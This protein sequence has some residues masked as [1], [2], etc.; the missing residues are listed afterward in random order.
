[1]R[2]SICRPES[3]TGSL[4]EGVKTF[5]NT[6]CTP[7]VLLK[8]T[9]TFIHP[10]QGINEKIKNENSNCHQSENHLLSC[11]SADLS[12]AYISSYKELD[13]TTSAG[14]SFQDNEGSS[15]LN[16]K[17]TSVQDN[18]GLDFQNNGGQGGQNNAGSVIQD[19]RGLNFQENGGFNFHN[20][21]GSDF[22]SKR[23]SDFQ[24]SGGSSFRK[25]ESDFQESEGSSFQK[26]GSDFQESEGSSSQVNRRSG[27]QNTRFSSSQSHLDEG[28][29]IHNDPN[30]GS[31][32]EIGSPNTVGLPS[33]QTGN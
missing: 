28:S 31:F 33:P 8:R 20:I 23:G 4:I 10:I 1:M 27:F 22:R 32:D 11:Q 29:N 6:P 14:L 19:N 9:S 25:K 7:D 30:L 18:R 5:S 13:L 26:R 16:N 3:I 24:E 15:F 21:R 12:Q 2:N 17:E